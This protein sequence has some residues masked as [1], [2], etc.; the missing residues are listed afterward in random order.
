MAKDNE[1]LLELSYIDPLT[2]L[3]NRITISLGL[4]Q[5]D[6]IENPEE[7]LD[8][9]IQGADKAL[10]MAKESGKNKCMICRI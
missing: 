8:M 6:I 3:F 5:K 1:K 2:G 9:I 10:Y 7:E 4:C